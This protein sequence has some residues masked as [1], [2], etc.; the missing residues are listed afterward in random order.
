MCSLILG[1]RDLRILNKY[2]IKCGWIILIFL[3]L[4]YFDF[5]VNAL[6]FILITKKK[7]SYNSRYQVSFR[8]LVL[9]WS[10]SWCFLFWLFVWLP[11]YLQIDVVLY[12][13]SSE[14]VFG[15]YSFLHIIF[16]Y[17]VSKW[18]FHVEGTS[19]RPSLCTSHSNRHIYG[20]MNITMI[21]YFTLSYAKP[22]LKSICLQL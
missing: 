19:E 18:S 16:L 17:Y 6:I 2:S 13:I 21:S 9:K 4:S 11:F 8:V 3:W 14:V 15:F 7:I 5:L 22:Y 1:P 12:V 10:F 20:W